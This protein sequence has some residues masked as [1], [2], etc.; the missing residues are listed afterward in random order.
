[1]NRE[2][3][4]KAADYVFNLPE[5]Y[6]GFDMMGFSEHGTPAESAHTCGA[7]G[8]FV[9]H[10]P[11][12]GIDPRRDEGWTEYS[13]RASGLDMLSG[14]W[15]WIFGQNWAFTDNTP[16]GAA[17][18]AYWLLDHGLPDDWHEQMMGFAPLCYTNK[19]STE[20]I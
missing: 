16:R 13:E 10:W 3:I 7:A 12:A 11:Q 17:Q 19:N 14:E 1:M 2:N 5:D 9:G 15:D 6:A 18:R 4:K 20:T 8:C